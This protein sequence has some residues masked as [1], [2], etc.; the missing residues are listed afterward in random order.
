MKLIF[1][2]KKIVE[3]DQRLSFTPILVFIV[4]SNTVIDFQDEKTIENRFPRL[5]VHVVS[6][7][8]KMRKPLET[9]RSVQNSRTPSNVTL[10]SL[11]C[12]SDPPWQLPRATS[13]WR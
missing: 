6:R 13:E 12:H 5:V 3:K 11:K 2:V 10:V 7:Y 9:S 1:E 4:I 8:P